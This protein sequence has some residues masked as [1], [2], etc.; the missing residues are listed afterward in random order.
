VPFDLNRLEVTGAA[1]RLEEVAHDTAR[2]FAHA[3]F[4]PSGI[5]AFRTGGITGLSNCSMAGQRGKNGIAW[6][7]S[8]AL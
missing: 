5:F 7:R 8:G 4:S 3:D 1:T 2:G 6:S